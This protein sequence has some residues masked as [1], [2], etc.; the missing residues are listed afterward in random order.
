MVRSAP[1]RSR[2]DVSAVPSEVD[3]PASVATDWKRWG[4]WAV[5][6]LGVVL[7]AVMAASLLRR[8]EKAEPGQSARI[9][10]LLAGGIVSHP[11]R[12]AAL[13]SDSG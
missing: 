3:A 8:P 11:S 4:L 9:G 10:G 1:L 12:Q 13:R 2:V 5:L 7:L 6:L